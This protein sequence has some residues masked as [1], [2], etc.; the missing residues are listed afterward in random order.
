[1]HCSLP[2]EA[3]KQEL[4]HVILE[5]QGH[6]SKEVEEMKRQLENASQEGG[7]SHHSYYRR[8]FNSIDLHDRKWYKLQDHHTTPN[9]M[10]KLIQTFQYIGVVNAH[11][12]YSCQHKIPLIKFFQQVAEVALHPKFQYD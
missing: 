9:W 7:G 5:A 3:K 11:S 2:T 8:T 12:I 4:I 6:S 1:V 10:P